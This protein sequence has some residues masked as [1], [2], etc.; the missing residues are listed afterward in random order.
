MAQ[1]HSWLAGNFT[2]PTPGHAEHDEEDSEVDDDPEGVERRRCYWAHRRA[3]KRSD[4]ALCRVLATKYRISPAVIARHYYW[5]PD[6]VRKAISNS[7]SPNDNVK[8]DRDNLPLM[9]P[10]IIKQPTT[11]AP[12]PSH[13]SSPA[14]HLENQ[15]PDGLPG[16]FIRDLATSAGLGSDWAKTLGDA[17]C[18]EGTLY[19]LAGLPKS[20]IDEFIAESFP[21]MTPAQKFLFIAAIERLRP[22]SSLSASRTI[23]QGPAGTSKG[24]IRDLATSAGLG[25]GWDKILVDSGC[26]EDTL[27][28]MAGLPKSKIDEFVAESFPQ[29]T[30]I[31]RFLFVA[32]IG[33]LPIPL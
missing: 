18:T 27:P 14:S 33:R 22:L 7:Y 2:P 28:R 26:N 25:F 15:Q 6:V 30:Q 8:E 16:R 13:T 20:K 23:S 12:K 9:F 3:L 19:R 11:V 17:G 4:R 32:A 5:G 24:F 29:M 10:R 31:Q 1:P 21:Q